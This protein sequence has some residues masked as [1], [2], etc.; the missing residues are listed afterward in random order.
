MEKIE[1]DEAA[2]ESLMAQ[3]PTD[4]DEVK[5]G[6]TGDGP[7]AGLDLSSMQFNPAMIFGSLPLVLEQLGQKIR[8][9]EFEITWPEGRKGKRSMGVNTYFILFEEV[10]PQVDTAGL[11]A[12]TDPS[13]PK[14]E[15]SPPPDYDPRTDK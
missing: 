13:A 10:Q 3:V 12:S 14:T 7:L 8:K 4:A 2:I 5:A 1:A 6:M 11:D 15:P 9:V